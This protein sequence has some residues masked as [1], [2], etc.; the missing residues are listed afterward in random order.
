MLYSLIKKK[1]KL[2]TVLNLGVLEDFAK[3]EKMYHWRNFAKFE[4]VVKFKAFLILISF[5]NIGKF[6][7]VVTF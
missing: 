4:N 5:D 3:F 2:R 7:N 1:K 6:D